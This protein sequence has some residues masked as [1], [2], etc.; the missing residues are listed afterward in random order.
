M[1][2]LGAESG[3][4][5]SGNIFRNHLVMSKKAFVTLRSGRSIGAGSPCFIVA[6]VGNNHQGDITLART[7]VEE[8]AAAGV[9]GVKFQKRNNAALLTQQGFAAPYT[10]ANSF[11][12]TYG[13]H[14]NA[15][16]LSLAEMAELQELAASLG[17]VFFASAWDASSLDDMASLDVELIK[18][19]SADL[20]N[21]PY[22]RSVGAMQT[23]VILSTGMS[24]YEQIDRAIAELQAFHNDIVILHC[25]SSYPCPDAEVCLPVMDALRERYHLPTGYSGHECGLGPSLAAVARGAVMIERHVTLDKSMRGTDHQVSLEPAEMKALVQ[26][27]REIE[28]SLQGNSKCLF[29]GE[30]AAAKKL[31]KSIVAARPLL[32]GTV[33]T[34]D[35]ITVKSPGTGI[36]PEYW[37]DVIGNTVTTDIAQDEQ[38]LCGVLAAAVNGAA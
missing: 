12:A 16:E 9:D 11:G 32:A 2:L 37:D 26:M 7:M 28:A 23:P 14:R 38:I 34:K 33:L 10:G 5:V 21:I 15:L 27:T 18:V 1:V 24:T 30:K 35:D 22:L 25:N 17:L 6:E 13:E 3:G 4:R 36:S 29:A 31:R 19:S 20:V 8:A